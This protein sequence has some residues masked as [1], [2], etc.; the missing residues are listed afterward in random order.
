[1]QKITAI[2]HH[3]TPM[4]VA[5]ATTDDDQSCYIS[6]AVA[7]RAELSVDDIGTRVTLAVVPNH[8]KAF[9]DTTPFTAVDI[10]FD[11]EEE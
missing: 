2:I 1:M 11:G 9:I 10:I 3:L 7:K 5:F 6:P 8:N 4:G